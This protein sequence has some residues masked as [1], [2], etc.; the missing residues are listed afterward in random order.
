LAEDADF[1]RLFVSFLFS[2]IFNWDFIS[3]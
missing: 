3:A 2:A 1:V